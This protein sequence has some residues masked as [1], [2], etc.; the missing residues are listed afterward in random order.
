MDLLNYYSIVDLLNYYSIVVTS[1]FLQMNPVLSL[2]LWLAVRD[3]SLKENLHIISVTVHI[4]EI[5]LF[6]V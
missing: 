4:S 1:P 3:W 6:K 2:L 5:I